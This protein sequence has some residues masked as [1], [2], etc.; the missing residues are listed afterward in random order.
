MCVVIRWWAMLM[1]QNLLA[2]SGELSLIKTASLLVKQSAWMSVS[3]AVLGGDEEGWVGG[4][5]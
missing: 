3:G 5:G 1:A 4:E 2:A